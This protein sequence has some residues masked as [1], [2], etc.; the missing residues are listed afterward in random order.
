MMATVPTQTNPRM[1]L[2]A[3]GGGVLL[4]TA[5]VVG[6]VSAF[7]VHEDAV[8]SAAIARQGALAQR[9]ALEVFESPAG[10]DATIDALRASMSIATEAEVADAV[11][12]LVE[13][14]ADMSQGASPEHRLALTRAAQAVERAADRAANERMPS[15]AAVFLPALIAGGAALIGVIFF[16]FALRKL[17]GRLDVPAR[18]VSGIAEA[19]A[20]G[21]LT[22]RAIFTDPAFRSAG[23]ALDGAIERFGGSVSSIRDSSRGLSQSSEELTAVSHQLAS[24]AEETSTRAS[25]VTSAAKGVSDNVQLVVAAAEQMNASVGEIARA[26]REASEIAGSA[27][28][29]AQST[30]ASVTRLGASSAEIGQVVKVITSI[31]EQTNL[32]ALNATIEAARAGEAGKGFAVVANEVKELAKETSRATDDIS[33]RIDTI[34]R[35]TTEAVKAIGRIDQVIQQVN[36]IQATI[37]AAVEEQSITTQEIQRNVAEAA[38]G[39]ADIADSVAGLAE[40]ARETSESASAIRIAARELSSMGVELQG[41]VGQFRVAGKTHSKV[42]SRSSS[43]SARGG[44]GYSNG[45]GSSAYGNGGIHPALADFDGPIIEM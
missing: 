39:S 36:E 1:R 32:L 7:N 40:A 28:D 9:Y 22:A 14:G 10:A 37:A 19:L 21:D 26:A 44:F 45:N 43:A 24:G 11:E 3:L 33:R 15:Y 6:A 4:L 27:V 17:R 12:T 23:D 38:Q 18:E 20:R 41:L 42:E 16:I 25:A 30:N 31:A 5:W 13:R 2:L 34:Q 35:D 8:A 29:A